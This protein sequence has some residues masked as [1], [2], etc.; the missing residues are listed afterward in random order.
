MAEELEP[1]IDKETGWFVF[2]DL[3]EEMFSMYEGMYNTTDR[4]RIVELVKGD[5]YGKTTKLD[6]TTISNL[7]A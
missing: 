5:F 4:E 7:H 3:R 1:V 6:A 2:P